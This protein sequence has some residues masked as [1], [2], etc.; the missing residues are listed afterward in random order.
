LPEDAS[1][2][3]ARFEDSPQ[4]TGFA[5][6]TPLAAQVSIWRFGKERGISLKNENCRLQIFGK[7]LI[8]FSTF[9]LIFS[10]CNDV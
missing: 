5:G 1:P 4:G 8:H 9:N 10:I 2:A 7:N 3:H 6:A